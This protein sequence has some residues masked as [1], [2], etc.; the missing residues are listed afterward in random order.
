M[1][2]G[3]QSAASFKEIVTFLGQLLQE[4]KKE[5]HIESLQNE[6]LRYRVAKE[7]IA[8]QAV[9]TLVGS[10]STALL[11]EIVTVWR[12]LLQELKKERDIES[13]REEVMRYRVAKEGI[14]RQAVA[15]L[16][17]SQSSAL[18][19]EIVITWRQLLQELKR[20]RDIESLREEVMQY[21]V[22][23]EG[24]A[25]QAVATLVGS[26]SST[27]LKEVVTSR[28]QLLR[29]LKKERH[30]ESLENEVLC[31][32]KPSIRCM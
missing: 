30:I 19:K 4:L 20:E 12:Q 22:A 32:R 7:G 5:R 18:L 8:R 24:A 21:R 23:K 15:T 29:E 1:I 31:Y 6:V 16:I 28:R 14:A 3:S 11:K 13:L 2:V 26:Q 27:L 10:Q 25:R 9:A 17:G